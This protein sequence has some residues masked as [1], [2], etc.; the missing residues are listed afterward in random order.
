MQSLKRVLIRILAIIA[1]PIGPATRRRIIRLLRQGFS[2]NGFDEEIKSIPTKRGIIEFYCLGQLPA[3]RAETL[4]TK[5]PETIEWIDTVASGDVFYDIGANIGTYSLYAAINR[6]VRVLAFEPLAA[7]YYLLNRNIE[8]NDLSDTATA[9]CL[10]LNDADLIDAFHVS[11]P[12]FGSALS[13]FAE[14]IDHNGK[15]LKAR[16]T[17]GMI[18][19]SLDNFIKKFDPPFPNHIKIDVDGIEDKIIAG[20]AQTL[21]DPRLKS[22]SIEL[23]ADRTDYAQTV[24]QALEAAGLAFVDRRRAAELDNTPYA[25][26]YNYRFQRGHLIETA[27][28]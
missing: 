1:S 27:Q 7:N 15:P 12:S 13:S 11:D 25:N 19:M 16:F 26:L 14:A 24:I 23:D 2:V 10:A 9:Y 17:Q 20:A 28:S 18:G 4:L 8:Q 6:E 21:A 3:W 22:V 5:E